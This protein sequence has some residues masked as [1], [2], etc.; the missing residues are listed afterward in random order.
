M[1]DTI[2]ARELLG[3]GKE[4]KFFTTSD[5]DL[6]LPY[7]KDVEEACQEIARRVGA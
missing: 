6:L 5:P 3:E 7:C 4:E 1:T 2:D